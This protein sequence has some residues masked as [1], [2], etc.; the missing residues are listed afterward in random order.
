MVSESGDRAA[1]AELGSRDLYFE[2]DRVRPTEL[3]LD[4]GTAGS[5]ALV[6]QTIATPLCLADGPSRVTLRGGT[7][8]PFS[9]TY[10]FLETDWVPAM[11]AVGLPLGVRL[12]KAGF[13]PVG[14][15][16]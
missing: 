1:G 9:P 6:L 11:E 3:S 2:P 5:T 4:I 15:G 16:R 12:V 14:G 10:E 13:R 8:V 7:H